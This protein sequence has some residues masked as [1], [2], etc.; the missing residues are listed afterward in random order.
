[1]NTPDAGTTRLSDHQPPKIDNSVNLPI[2]T[3]SGLPTGIGLGPGDG[4]SIGTGRALVLSRA[5]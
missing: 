2:D 4:V 3:K 5:A 1:M